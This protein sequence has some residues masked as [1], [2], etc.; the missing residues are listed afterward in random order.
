M[1]VWC[2]VETYITDKTEISSDESDESDHS[3]KKSMYIKLLS[4]FLK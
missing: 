1:Q 4:Y 3:D 2:K